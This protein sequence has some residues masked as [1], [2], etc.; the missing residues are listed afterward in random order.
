MTRMRSGNLP[1]V[2]TLETSRLRLRTHRPEDLPQCAAMWADPAVTRYI[3][4]EPCSEPRTWLRLLAYLGHWAAMG[5]GY[6]VM[7]DRGSGEF[8]G[9]IGFADFKRDIA[10]P[11]K[12]CPELGFALASRFH[13]KGYATE[14]AQA[15]VAWADASLA[16]TRTVCL[17]DP[18]NLASLRVVEKCG[19]QVFERGVHG[20]RPAMFLQRRTP[21]KGTG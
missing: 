13:G 2:P 8:V 1:P 10:P 6:W 9:E 16:A 14:G 12:G 5:F 11:M 19:Y 21:V 7:E 20:G 17:I 4:G 3:G 18:Q 15:V